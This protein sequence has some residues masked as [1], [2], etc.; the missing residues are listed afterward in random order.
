MQRRTVLGGIA[1]AAA[2]GYL[3]RE[4]QP[5]ERTP[6][7]ADTS[8]D[9]SIS[10]ETETPSTAGFDPAVI[11]ERFIERFNAM[12]EEQ[13][14]GDVHRDRFL[15]EMGQEHAAN[16]AEHDY[17]GHTQPDTGMGITDRYRDRNLLP[18]CELDAG[19]GT[20]YPGA[21]NAAGA[22]EGR[23]TH[24]NTDKTFTIATADDLARY[25]LD[26]WLQSPPHRKVMLLPAVSAIGLGVA[27]SG[28]DIYAALEF[29]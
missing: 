11:E 22:R 24:P 8:G 13:G 19:D 25:L 20:F 3:F 29:C 4:Q 7:S 9:G 23:V 6:D 10:A 1:A 14:L 27:Q 5:A 26:T 12:R 28:D 15:S 17:I 16:M 2:G 18:E 21:E